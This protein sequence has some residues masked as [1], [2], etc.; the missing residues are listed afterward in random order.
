MNELIL[1]S[2]DDFH[3]HVRDDDMLALV[4]AHTTRQFSRAII[5]PNLKAPIT[6]V[7]QARKYRER[8]LAVIPADVKFKPLMTLYLTENLTKK[9]VEKAAAHPDIYGIKYYPAGATTNSDSGVQN[10]KTVYPLLEIMEKYCLPLLVH[11]EVTD[12][13]VDIFDREA[14]FIERVLHPLKMDF[15]ELKIVFEHITTQ[16]AMQYV[17]DADNYLA[18]T[19]TPQHLL[20]NRNELFKSGIRPHYYCLPVLKRERHRKALIEAAISGHPRFFLGTDSA[21]HT[22][23]NKESSCGCAGIYS[24]SNAIEFYATIFDQNNA[25]DMLEKFASR[26]GANFYGL[27]KNTSKIKLK[28]EQWKVPASFQFSGG[29]LVPLGAGETLTWKMEA[30]I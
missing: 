28:K 10:L 30:V 6:T 25:L 26:N 13:E 23:E 15:P 8:I 12:S 11:G 16:Q 4:I 14:V 3:L 29:E 7:E 17:W 18:A 22:R 24:A 19:I 27:E 1:T 20:Y 5:M 21:P 2:P 9:E